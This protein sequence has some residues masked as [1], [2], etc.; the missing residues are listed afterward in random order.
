MKKILKYTALL[1][2]ALL[3][4]SCSKDEP[5]NTSTVNL[6]GEWAVTV[7]AVIGGETIEDAFGLGEFMIITYNTNADDGKEMWINDL[8]QF[9]NFIVKVPCNPS[10]R[11]FGAPGFRPDAANE[12]VEV[13]VTEGSVVPRGAISPTGKPVD[14]I[15]FR[16]NFSDDENGVDYYLVHGYRRTGFDGYL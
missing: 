9:W 2:V 7:D 14:A 12:G 1:V 13:E 4:G 6:A 5:G 16:V 15:S 8:E 10:A 3:L 11:T